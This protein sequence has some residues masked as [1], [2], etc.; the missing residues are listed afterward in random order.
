[1]E[2]TLSNHAVM[3]LEERAVPLALLEACI[4]EPDRI[5]K[6]I[7][8]TVHYCK[9]FERQGGRWLRVVVNNRR[10]PPLVVTA[11]FDRRLRRSYDDTNR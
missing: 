2:Y 8:G 11:F 5:E 7:D 1:M 9:R 6:R 4:A 3:A 10:D